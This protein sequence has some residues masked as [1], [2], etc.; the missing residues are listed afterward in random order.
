MVVMLAAKA[1]V[2]SDIDFGPKSP[3]VPNAAPFQP[4]FL[5]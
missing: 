5:G 4:P 2:M 3:E 1:L